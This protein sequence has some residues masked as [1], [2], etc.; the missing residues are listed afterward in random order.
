MSG[1]QVIN[2]EALKVLNRYFDDWRKR[3]PKA[4]IPETFTFTPSSPIWP[5]LQSTPFFKTIKWTLDGTGR[6]I[7]SIPKK[8]LRDPLR[9]RFHGATMSWRI[10]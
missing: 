2:D 9:W 5:S 6:T 10:V 4:Q 7:G 1:T 3:N 8:G